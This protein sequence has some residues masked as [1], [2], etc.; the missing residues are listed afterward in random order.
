MHL[1][2]DQ[3]RDPGRRLRNRGRR[4]LLAGQELLGLGL[5][6]ERLDQDQEG[7]QRVRHRQLLLRGP[8]REDHR[9]ALRPPSHPA[10]GHSPAETAVRHFQVT[11]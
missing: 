2:G 8:V 3:P 10:T 7:H 4:Q 11:P 5:G 1:R 6:Q 9:Q